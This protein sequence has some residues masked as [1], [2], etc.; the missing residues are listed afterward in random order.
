MNILGYTY[1]FLEDEMQKVF[2]YYG[3]FDDDGNWKDNMDE[4]N[5]ELKDG[6]EITNSLLEKSLRFSKKSK[7]V[8][9][10]FESSEKVVAQIILNK[11]FSQDPLRLEIGSGL[12]PLANGELGGKLTEKI[13]D[14]RKKINF[15][16]VRIVD[17]LLLDRWEYKFFSY[18]VTVFGGFVNDKE[19][20]DEQE[21]TVV[22]A[23]DDYIQ[24]KYVYYE[25]K[26]VSS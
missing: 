13:K 6:W 12:I 8:D 14:L 21:T 17:N 2:K 5:N 25:T 4:L 3:V 22:K 10:T 23:I 9:S 11:D 15:P 26:D 1:I 16:K 18:D 20:I 24:G 19:S 7:S